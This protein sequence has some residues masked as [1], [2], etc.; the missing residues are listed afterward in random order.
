MDYETRKLSDN[1]IFIR[2]HRI[3]FASE[4][5]ESEQAFVAELKHYLDEATQT[6]YFVSDLRRGHITNVR[7]L[8]KMGELTE[9]PYWGGGVSY[10]IKASTGLLVDTFE[11]IALN[12]TGDHMARTIGEVGEYLE[13]LKPGIMKGINLHA[14][15][16]I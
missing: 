12:K 9:H 13:T 2:W 6:I 11:R 15:F 7:A 1:L 16:G 14:V 8:R 10:G 3:S 5:S 4:V